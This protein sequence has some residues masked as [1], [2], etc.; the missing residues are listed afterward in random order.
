MPIGQHYGWMNEMMG[1]GMW[2]IPWG[3]ILIIIL[4]VILI[5]AVAGRGGNRPAGPS[6][7]LHMEDKQDLETPLDILKKRYARGEISRDDFEQMKKD[8]SS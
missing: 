8:L 3:W 5:Y 4:V 7:G 6:M 1:W 2:M